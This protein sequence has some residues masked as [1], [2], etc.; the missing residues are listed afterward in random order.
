M[1]NASIHKQTEYYVRTLNSVATFSSLSGDFVFC[2]LHPR[3]PRCKATALKKTR[4]LNRV[5][6]FT[7]KDPVGDADVVLT[8]NDIEKTM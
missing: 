8:S 1:H 5:R 6:H 4:I 3:F 7:W 2:R